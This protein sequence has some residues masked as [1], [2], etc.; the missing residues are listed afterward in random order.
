MSFFV[1]KRRQRL[2]RLIDRRRLRNKSFSL[3]SNDCWGAEVYKH[4]DM[5]FNTPFI[6]LM[7]Q[8][9]CFVKLA[10]NPRHY[11]AQPLVFHAESRYAS[12]NELRTRLDHYVPLA[13]LGGD[14]EITFLH[15]H[16]DEEARAKWNKRARRVRWDNVYF[17]F[18]GSKDSAT[19]EL[20]QEFDQIPYPHLTLLREPQPGIGS[21]IVVPHYILDGLQQFE[22]SLPH[23]DL[24]GW[25]NGGGLHPG[26]ALRLYSK[27]FFPII[28]PGK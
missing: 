2:G 3:I 10:Q 7:L 6:G 20:V 22:R 15:Y 8:A 11:L 16:S 4:F 5:P 24:V 12:I 27:V 14:V 28:F 18:D 25:L 17:K 9:P 19:P 13:T 21:A 26:P 1:D 23:F